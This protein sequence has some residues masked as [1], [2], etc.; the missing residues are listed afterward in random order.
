MTQSNE[1]IA[2]PKLIPEQTL[3]VAAKSLIL[4]TAADA[5]DLATAIAR[6][7]FY[8]EISWCGGDIETFD[9][10][11]C[12]YVYTESNL[13]RD[14]ATRICGGLQNRMNVSSLHKLM[15]TLDDAGR[16]FERFYQSKHR[17]R[18]LQQAEAI[19]W[20]VAMVS[21]HGFMLTS[22][23]FTRRAYRRFLTAAWCVV[24]QWP[25]VV[26]AYFKLGLLGEFERHHLLSKRIAAQKP[27]CQA[28]TYQQ[29]LSAPLRSLLAQIE[30]FEPVLSLSDFDI[31]YD[32]WLRLTP[33][34]SYDHW[35][36]KRLKAMV[37][38]LPARLRQAATRSLDD[39][40]ANL[41]SPPSWRRESGVLSYRGVNCE[42]NRPADKQRTLLDAF[43]DC[44]WGHAVR[45]PFVLADKTN[46][47]VF[48]DTV[49]DL[50][51]KCRATSLPIRFSIGSD[52]Q[53]AHWQ[54]TSQQP[55][56]QPRQRLQ[57]NILEPSQML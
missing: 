28:V 52:H 53:T 3:K 47:S 55:L 45:C 18:L 41:P 57:R 34:D 26:R 36:W 37:E 12:D 29:W 38:A 10:R 42:Y 20:E 7:H 51:K 48:K 22:S 44:K 27:I 31:G 43:E 16:D 6:R 39:A 32:L 13:I 9:D 50:N 5:F 56:V 19:D 21:Q 15:R 2:S 49:T 54:D 33:Q 14:A 1:T 11:P 8:C 4:A 23:P 25:P 24:A 40:A 35:A 46:Y 30:E 17:Y